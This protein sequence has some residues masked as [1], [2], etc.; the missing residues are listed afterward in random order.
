MSERR[1]GWSSFLVELRDS[2]NESNA[3][4]KRL[5]LA[6]ED[7][8]KCL[9][10]FKEKVEDYPQSDHL[11][12]FDL[13]EEA[14]EMDIYKLKT[15]LDSAQ[16]AQTNLR[17]TISVKENDL[18]LLQERILDVSRFSL[19]EADGCLEHLPLRC[20][21]WNEDGEYGKRILHIERK[22]CTTNERTRS[23]DQVSETMQEFNAHLYHFQRTTL[24][25]HHATGDGNH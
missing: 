5:E 19:S 13:Q 16:M 7:Q 17:E 24:T 1:Q 20:L 14:L 9:Q 10:E 6:Q 11:W 23:T 22:I 4:E 25:D 18:R 2:R 8:D 15:E 21:V 3:L 12:S